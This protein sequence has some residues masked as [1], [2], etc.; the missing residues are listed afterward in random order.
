MGT[1]GLSGS[2]LGRESRGCLQHY[3]TDMRNRIR[4][5]LAP[6]LDGCNGKLQS[7]ETGE[8]LEFGGCCLEIRGL[9]Y[10]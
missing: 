8:E 2:R 3:K 1:G 9:L 6:H 10:W 5:R 7:N 4:K